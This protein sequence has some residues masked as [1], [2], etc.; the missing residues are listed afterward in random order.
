MT[1]RA[2]KCPQCNAPLPPAGRFA[3][4]VVCH[5]C[6]TTVLLDEQA[7]SVARFRAAFADWNSPARHGFTRWISIG[8]MVG[9]SHWALGDIVGRGEI[10]D[11]YAAQRARWPTERAL[12]KVLRDRRDAASFDHE[13]EVLTALQGSPTAGAETFTLRL[14]Q[15][16]AHGDVSPGSA[17]TA[18]T[19]AGSRALV[20]RWADGFVHTFEDVARA[21]PG[22]ALKPIS[23]GSAGKKGGFWSFLRG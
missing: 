12:V 21:C 14:P 19:P 1:E 5:F 10:S 17:G 15:P 13:W 6:N 11:V 7:I 9:E 23:P 22:E 4:S 2:L 20:L 16:I 8:A 3:R 18:G